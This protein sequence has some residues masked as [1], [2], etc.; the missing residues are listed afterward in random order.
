[1]I[2][3]MPPLIQ[4]EEMEA[5]RAAMRE[6]KTH[7]KRPQ[8]YFIET[9]GCQMN[10]HDSETIAGML[11]EMGML[12]VEDKE[13]ADLILFNTCCIR[14]N[15]E[16][17]ALGNM[18][19]LKQLKK[20]RPGI[21]LCVCG[22]MMQQ[23]KMAQIIL[24]QYPYFDVAFG[25]HALY[26]FPSL[27]LRALETRRQVLAMA[28]EP[29]CIAEGMPVRREHPYKAFVTIMYGCNNFCSYCIVP[30]VRGRERSRGIDAVVRECETLLR[31]GVKEVTLL[32]QNVN[33]YGNDLAGEAS[34]PELLKRLDALGVPRIR[35][36]TS[37]PKDLSD[38]LIDV[39]AASK[40]VAGHLHLPVQSGSD[41]ILLA[42]NRIYNRD[43][44]L[45]RVDAL[46]SAI[47][48]IAL[49]T[50][51]IVGF[52]GETD[53]DFDDTA[54]LVQAVRYDSAFTFIYSE[55]L[56]TRAAS[57]PE[58][59]PQEVAADRIARLIALQ[60]GIT[61]EVYAGLVGSV[62]TVLVEETS[63]R[64]A[65]EIT[66]KCERNITCNMK[67]DPALI[68]QFVPVRIIEAKH[69]TLKAEL[70]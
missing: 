35:F 60:E 24:R 25:T 65:S 29:G 21:V 6:I 27:L 50:D 51:I 10:A 57:L 8:F 53:A 49:T 34:F 15:A 62:Q 12:P 63:R 30:Y 55:R 20:R 54:S 33:S 9:Y 41:R 19:W 32:G 2:R 4:E 36:M 69:N 48:D 45:R 47:P 31:E 11:G 44:Y 23:P 14:D 61:R 43:T 28:D 26:R 70:I 52:P 46:R 64:D 13:A 59:V 66:G 39:M 40:R 37:H 18:T 68:G 67:G 3:E 17:K 56:G 16:R 38:S 22:C 1:M 5:Q 7:E 58:Q 42:M